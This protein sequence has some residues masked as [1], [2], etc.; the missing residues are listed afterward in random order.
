M[1]LCSHLVDS[2]IKVQ[3]FIIISIRDSL[4]PSVLRGSVCIDF[5]LTKK[6][7]QETAFLIVWLDVVVL[8][9]D[10]WWESEGSST[11]GKGKKETSI[12]IHSGDTTSISADQ[13]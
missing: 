9:L 7:Q 6:D 8:K 4:R 1:Y 11:I 13:N 12:F 3:S 2:Q 5:F 10:V